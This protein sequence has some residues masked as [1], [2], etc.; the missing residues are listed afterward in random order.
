MGGYC[1]LFVLHNEEAAPVPK[2]LH[3]RPG[4]WGPLYL[5]GGA[6]Y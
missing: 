6:W 4:L 3:R 5:E 2:V 1:L